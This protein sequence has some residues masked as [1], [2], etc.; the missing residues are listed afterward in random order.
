[1]AEQKDNYVIWMEFDDEYMDFLNKKCEELAENEI[2]QGF[3]PPHLTLTFVENC[4]EQ[5]LIQ[6][7]EEFFEN[8]EV[9]LFINS[10][11]SFSGG[12]IFYAPRATK[13]LLELQRNYCEGLKGIGDLAWDLYY[14]ENWNPHIALTGVLNDE[15]AIKAFSIMKKEFNGTNAIVK[16]VVIRKNG[17]LLAEINTNVNLSSL[18]HFTYEDISVLQKYKYQG[19]APQEIQQKIDT[20]NSKHCD[21]KYFDMFA[22]TDEDKVVGMVSLYQHTTDSISCGPEIFAEYRNKGYGTKAVSQALDIGKR[23]GYKIAVAQIRKDNH[24]SIHIHE[25]L[26]FELDHEYVNKRG[27]EVGFFIKHIG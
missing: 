22:V 4:D 10:V 21:D 18:R 8:K 16:K 13:E 9:E 15:D 2:K 17:T 23:N 6:Y 19:S 3:K 14:P 7:T 20:W 1:M 12:V 24:E 5:K 27:N 11:G 25:K 26:G